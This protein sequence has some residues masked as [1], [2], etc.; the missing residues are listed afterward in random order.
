MKGG[1]RYLWLLAAVA[2][3]VVIATMLLYIGLNRQETAQ[4][5]LPSPAASGSP[6]DGPEDFSGSIRKIEVN[7]ET[8][9]AVLAYLPR[10]DSYG[11]R[12]SVETFWGEGSGVTSL[13][14]WRLGGSERITVGEG[15]SSQNILLQNGTVYVWYDDPSRAYSGRAASDD[16]DRWQRIYSYEAQLSE[17]ID[18]TEAGYTAYNGEPCVFAAF[19]SPAFGYDCKLYVS[20]RSGLLLGSETYEGDKPVLRMSSSDLDTT[21]PDSSIFAAPSMNPAG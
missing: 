19:K 2:V 17:E 7:P 8:V 3:A 1:Q 6:S 14:V 13:F 18:I 16:A 11:R 4:V 20:V 10:T 12:L 15:L 9:R 21:P 5:L